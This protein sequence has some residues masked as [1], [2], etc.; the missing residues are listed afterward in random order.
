MVLQ[1]LLNSSCL[2]FVSCI[3][4]SPT[5]QLVWVSFS[6]PII[7]AWVSLSVV[8]AALPQLLSPSGLTCNIRS[9]FYGGVDWYMQLILPIE[10][11]LCMFP[12]SV[13]HWLFRG[14]M[15]SSKHGFFIHLLPTMYWYGVLRLSCSWQSVSDLPFG[16]ILGHSVHSQVGRYLLVS[17]MLSGL[18]TTYSMRS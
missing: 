18:Y 8:V 16:L 11:T 2:S 9:F 17:S 1:T 15:V 14:T 6:P 3:S 13:M 10:L 7:C 4:P 12:H 5:P